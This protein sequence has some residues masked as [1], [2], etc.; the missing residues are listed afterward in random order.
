MTAVEEKST[1]FRVDVKMGEEYTLKQLNK[2]EILEILKSFGV[3]TEPDKSFKPDLET[4]ERC[5]NNP[6]P[7]GRCMLEV[8]MERQ[9]KFGKSCDSGYRTI[10]EQE[11]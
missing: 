6:N 9:D 1:D 4:I 5:R 7:Y 11:E 3:K 2:E 10:K 8:I